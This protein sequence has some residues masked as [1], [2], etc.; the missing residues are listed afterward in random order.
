MSIEPKT[1]ADSDKLGLV[2]RKFLDEDPSLQANYDHETGQ[3]IL[4]GMG[5]LHLEI[6]IDRMKR[7]FGLETNIGRP[8]VA[9]KETIT[10][11]VKDIDGKF[12]QQSGGRGQYGHVVINVEPLEKG[13]GFE[14]VDMIKGGSIPREY[15]PAAKK[16]FQEGILS[17]ILAGYPVTDLRVTL[18]DGSYHD[19][20]SSEMAFQLAARMALKEGLSKGKSVFLEPIMNVE[21]ECPEEQ[22]SSVIGDLN[23]RRAK[24]LNM[25]S[26]ANLKTGHC[27][28]PLSEMFNYVNA[29]RSLTQGRG[30]FNM[31]PAYYQQVPSNV[32]EKI[33]GARQQVPGRR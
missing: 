12:V 7:E 22:M 14:F 19:V 33:I 23:S 27:E 20:D 18:I 6:I 32:S 29:L 15:I 9:Y 11:A 4:S 25:G 10:R 16:G 21:I 30:T 2:L 5:E 8:E 28:V 17:G 26:R 13:S 1:K 3:T 31:E 24:I